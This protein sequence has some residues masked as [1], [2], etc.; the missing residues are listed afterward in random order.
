MC[1][2][3]EEG[4]V[5]CLGW[6]DVLVISISSVNFLVKNFLCTFAYFKISYTANFTTIN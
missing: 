4:G 3:W 2:L 1:C 6:A 5:F